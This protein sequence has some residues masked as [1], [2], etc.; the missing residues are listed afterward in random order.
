MKR[1][2]F[3]LPELE[4]KLDALAEGTLH[5][6]SR[7]ITNGYSVQIVQQWDA[8]ATL[9]RVTHASLVLLTMA[10]C[11]GDDSRRRRNVVRTSQCSCSSFLKPSSKPIRTEASSH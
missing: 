2:N 7:A 9:P 10:Y 8:C 5:P 4:Q 1:W 3:T 11:S 6:I